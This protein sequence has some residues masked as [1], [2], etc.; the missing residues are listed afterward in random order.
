ML[1]AAASPCSPGAVATLNG[2]W[3]AAPGSPLSDRSGASLEL[4]GTRV[5][6]NGQSA[7]VLY[8]SADRVDF[9]CPALPA[10][11]PLSVTVAS[12]F[13]TSLPVTVAMQDA[14]P[15]IMS[16]SDLPLSQGLI[17]FSGANDL[18]MER[19]FL[20]ASHPAQPGDQ[21]AIL[22]TGL[23]TAAESLS[24]TMLVKLS[25]VYAAVESVEPVAGYAGVYSIQ[26]RVP[27][28]MT[29]GQVPV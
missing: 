18:V 5:T 28:A 27:A 4:G 1:T 6:V 29:F 2:E 14:V 11:T 15:T 22:A 17:S 21:I 13:G 3:L 24:R 20:V 25:D 9:L 26:T 7:A 16:L 19:N 12:A 23:G 8:S 10:G